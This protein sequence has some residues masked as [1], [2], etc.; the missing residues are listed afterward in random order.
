MRVSA[1]VQFIDEALLTDT[2]GCIVWPF[3]RDRYGYG[4]FNNRAA[5]AVVCERA[6]GLK[7]TAAHQAAHSCGNRACINKRHLRWATGAEN[8]E[9]QRQH[10]TLAR[11]EKQALAKLKEDDVRAIRAATG[12]L[13]E[14]ASRYGV[15]FNAVWK[16]RRGITWSHIQ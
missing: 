9:D 13:R 14:I 4:A 6:H 11:G 16:I 5:S 3:A 7:P 2:D 10:G 8:M 15:K 1:R 12:T